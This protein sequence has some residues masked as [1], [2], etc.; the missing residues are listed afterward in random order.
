MN[1]PNDNNQQKPNKS[2]R[3]SNPLETIV[4]CFRCKDNKATYRIRSSVPVDP[5]IWFNVCDECKDFFG[6]DRVQIKN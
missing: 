5:F 2:K 3:Q 6:N 4:M 1:K